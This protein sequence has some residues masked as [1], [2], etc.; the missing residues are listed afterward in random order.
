[1]QTL[2]DINPHLGLLASETHVSDGER[3]WHRWVGR[4]ER[5]LG[6]DLDGNQER[7]GYSLDYAHDQ[8]ERGDTPEAYAAQV[9]KES[10][11]PQGAA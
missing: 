5:L 10:G 3:A 11:P 4:V 6:H 9:K 2:A 8:F 7:N 1:M